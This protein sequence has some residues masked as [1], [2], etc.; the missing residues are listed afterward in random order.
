MN[1]VDT[2]TWYGTL[3]EVLVQRVYLIGMFP[4]PSYLWSSHGFK[5]RTGSADSTGSIVNRTLIRSDSFKNRKFTKS[6]K[7]KKKTGN[8]WFNRK[9]CKPDWFDRFR[10]ECQNSFGVKRR[11]NSSDNHL[12]AVLMLNRNIFKWLCS[13][14]AKPMYALCIL[15]G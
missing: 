9:N 14:T 4:G 3:L 10:I 12:F 5:N 7:I 11:R 8:Q 15:T 2:G 13:K 6:K 1:Y